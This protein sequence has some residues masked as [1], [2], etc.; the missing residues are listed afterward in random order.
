MKQMSWESGL[1][2]TENPR[3]AASARTSAFDGV[4]PS[5]NIECA[6]CSAVS[7]PNT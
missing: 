7:T 5:G 3:A 4:A 1:F 6:S 2:A